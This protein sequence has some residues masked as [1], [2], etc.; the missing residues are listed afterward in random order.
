MQN[1]TEQSTKENSQLFDLE[2]FDFKP[3]NKGLGFHHSESNK[4]PT[5]SK[6][7][8]ASSKSPSKSLSTRQNVAPKTQAKTSSSAVP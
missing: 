7:S 5:I 6:V 2:E 3:I 8:T 1:T 4:I